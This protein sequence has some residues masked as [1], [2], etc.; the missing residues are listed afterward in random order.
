VSDGVLTEKC[1]SL[2]GTCDD[3]AKQFKGVFMRYFT[4]LDDTTHEA[5]Y[6]AFVDR[7]AT[8]VWD[9]DRDAR[10][11]L[12]ERWSGAEST[13]HPNVFDWRTQA[14]ALSALLAATLPPG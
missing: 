3:N 13:A 8:S 2:D 9:R 11:Q 4:D 1:D 10:N 6:Q 7:Q 14:S 12:G 5:R